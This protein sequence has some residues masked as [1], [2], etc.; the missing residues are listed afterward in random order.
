MWKVSRNY[1]FV[2]F[3]IIVLVCVM[4]S[5][6]VK[7]T[8]ESSNEASGTVN[9]REEINR[10]NMVDPRRFPPVFSQSKEEELITV[11]ELKSGSDSGKV[12]K[13][14]KDDITLMKNYVKNVPA[15]PSCY[16][17]IKTALGGMYKPNNTI[18]ISVL[19]YGFRMLH[20]NLVASLIRLNITNNWL[21]IALD[22][23]SR[24]WLEDL[25][26][27]CF[28]DAHR[29]AYKPESS[30][31]DSFQIWKTGEL[32]KELH[33]IIS[34]STSSDFVSTSDS[35]NLNFELS[36]Y[37]TDSIFK[38]ST[39][40]SRY[41]EVVYTKAYYIS[42]I[43]EYGVNV[44]FI[45]G[46]LVFLRDPYTF[47]PRIFKDGWINRLDDTPADIVCQVDYKAGF[48]TGFMLY[49]SNEKVRRFAKEVVSIQ[50]L[51]N[52]QVNNQPAMNSLLASRRWSSKIKLVP[53]PE[54]LFPCGFHYWPKRTRTSMG[55]PLPLLEQKLVVI[56]NNW[57]KGLK[58]KIDRWIEKNHWYVTINLDGERLFDFEEELKS[59]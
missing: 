44:F 31:A 23:K 43:L 4:T 12:I 16:T 59:R 57:I 1:V 15:R 17:D 9:M 22:E 39:S 20:S 35:E 34:N 14:M 49:M 21:L 7:I 58:K 2:V 27:P 55:A 6:G 54:T 53:L 32:P 25:R 52:G 42:K 8:L 5:G 11:A 36:K 46:D 28:Y 26:L 37:T 41:T 10:L 33:N 24:D 29:A 13:R 3:I 56:H 30:G 18:Y 19:N 38:K 40:T 50:K 51:S 47:F 45:D 48:N